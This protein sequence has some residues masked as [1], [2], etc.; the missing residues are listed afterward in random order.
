MRFDDGA[1][2]VLAKATLNGI[3]REGGVP[4]V[5]VAL[6]QLREAGRIEVEGG[7]RLQTRRYVKGVD[8]VRKQQRLYVFLYGDESFAS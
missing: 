2:G 1:V 8:G 5:D 6:E 7:S 3:A 4:D